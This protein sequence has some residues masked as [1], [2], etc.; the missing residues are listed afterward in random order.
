MQTLQRKPLPPPQY[1]LR[2]EIDYQEHLIRYIDTRIAP[3]NPTKA[4]RALCQ[5]EAWSIVE[6]EFLAAKQSFSQPFN[7]ITI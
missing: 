2:S 4:A 7:T 3:H 1:P 6:L 5:L